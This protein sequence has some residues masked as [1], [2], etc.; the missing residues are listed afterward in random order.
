MVEPIIELELYLA[1]HGE[2]RSNA[3]LGDAAD[4]RGWEDPPLSEKGETQARLLGEF[5][6]RM[7]FD[8]VLASGLD[9]AVQTAGAVALRQT[10][11]RTVEVSPLFSENGTPPAFGIKTLDELKQKF[12]FVIPAAG[13]DETGSFVSVEEDPSDERRLARGHEALGYLRRRFHHGEKVFLAAHANFNTFFIL[14]ALGQSADPD[15]DFA[16]ANTG[17]TKLVFYAP[18]TGRWGEDTHVIYHNERSHLAAVYPEDLL[19]K[20]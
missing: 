2:S 15:F 17:V 14:A 20:L 13:A 16:F 4:V 11:A 6:A 10:K 7:P 12:P 1:R 9:R 8:C 19:T 18:G 5:Y 3:G